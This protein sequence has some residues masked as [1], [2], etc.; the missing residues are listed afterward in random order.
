LNEPI[1]ITLA[2]AE[3]FLSRYRVPHALIGGLAVSYRGFPR[4]T[5]DVEIVIAVD[6]KE[7]LDLIPALD[8]S[9]FRPLFEAVEEVVERSFILPLVHKLSNVKVDLSI[10]LSGF[11]RQVVARAEL[12]QLSGTAIRVAT[13]EDLIIMKALAGRPQDDQDQRGL[14]IA[15]R[16]YLDW[17]YCESTAEALGEALSQDLVGRLRLIRDAE[18]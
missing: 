4:S 2:D 13:T 9:P 17:N 7:A 16:E 5:A 6:L 3:A 8:G 1:P 11:E 15:Q 18:P 12:A 14:I 10:N